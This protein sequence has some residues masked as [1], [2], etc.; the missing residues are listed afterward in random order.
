MLFSESSLGIEMRERELRV[1]RCI[2][3]KN[4]QYVRVVFV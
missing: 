1:Y 3:M 4:M 2:E